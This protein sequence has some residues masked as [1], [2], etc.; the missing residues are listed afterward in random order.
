MSNIRVAELRWD[1][2]LRFTG[3]I[4]GGATIKIDAGGDTAPGPMVQL[5]LAAGACSGADVVSILQKMQVGLERCEMT[6]TGAR[7]EEHPRRYLSIHYRFSLAGSGLDEVKARR[8]IDLSIEKYCS[9]LHSLNPD[10]A[11][12]YDLELG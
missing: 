5:L 11:V 9:V 10:I 1:G 12:S 6:V 4:P 3:G 8:A 7:Q 2:D